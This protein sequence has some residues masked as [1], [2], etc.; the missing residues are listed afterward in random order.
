KN[1]NAFGFG[2]I[3]RNDFDIAR[4]GL[5]ATSRVSSP[6]QF[7]APLRGLPV[8]KAQSRS[9]SFKRRQA[10]IFSCEILCEE[11]SKVPSKSVTTKRMQG[12]ET[13]E[14]GAFPSSSEVGGM[15]KREG[16]KKG[17]K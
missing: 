8:A 3:T 4:D 17:G 9:H 7:T 10:S 6:I 13:H 2:D 5:N 12:G 15:L 11:F 16:E 14:G 1:I